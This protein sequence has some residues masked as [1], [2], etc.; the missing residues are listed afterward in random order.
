MS[1]DAWRVEERSG[2]AVWLFR[3]GEAIAAGPARDRDGSRQRQAG[4]SPLKAC[5][6]S[7]LGPQTP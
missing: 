4:R 6:H 2:V 3:I 7:L 1:V 5:V